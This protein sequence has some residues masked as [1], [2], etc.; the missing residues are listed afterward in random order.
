MDAR[1]Y[2][3]RLGRLSVELA[4][5]TAPWLA[6]ALLLTA[7]ILGSRR[8]A[9]VLLE[10]LG[11]VSLLA[12]A[13]SVGA[14]ALIGRKAWRFG[15]TSARAGVPDPLVGLLFSTAVFATGAAVSLPDT[16]AGGL[17]ALWLILA[18]E[19]AWAWRPSRWR[20]IFPFS[21]RAA[22]ADSA[23]PVERS[24]AA[25]VTHRPQTLP[26]EPIGDG[27]P[28]AHVTQQLTR[29][30][31]SDGTELL[32]GWLRVPLAAGQRT[33]NVHVAFCPPFSH[34]PRA[35]IE[36]TDGPAARIKTVQVLSFGARFDLKLVETSEI[37]STVLLR[38]SAEASQ[39]PT[40]T[41]EPADSK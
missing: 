8:L 27:P 22:S 23:L 19:E 10:P 34:V 40:T 36:Q 13:L 14:M 18:G 7:A 2:A 29:L 20:R 21:G 35:T 30:R 17:V 38:F 41:N 12:V 5:W 39:L 6:T 37:S 9:G 26:L 25:P 33:A 28:D 11:F 16:S 24:L 31:T 15:Q 3:P 4:R 32:A 1:T